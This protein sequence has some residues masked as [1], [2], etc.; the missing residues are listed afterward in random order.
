MRKKIKKLSEYSVFYLVL[1]V[2]FFSILALSMFNYFVFLS[3]SQKTYRE[4]FLNY[5]QKVTDLA[6]RNIDQQI[7][8]VIYNIPQ[9]YFSDTKQNDAFLKPQEEKLE[10]R[11]AEITNLISGLRLIQVSY[12]IIESMDLYYE[13]TRTVVTGFSNVHF[14]G[15]IEELEKFLP[16]YQEF[17]QQ[18]NDLYFMEEST[19]VYPAHEPVLTYVR[20]IAFPRWEGS[21]VV[22]AL[23]ISAS[24]FSDYIDESVGCLKIQ[25][26]DRRILYQ[27]SGHEDEAAENKTVLT[28]ESSTTS[29]SYEYAIADSVLYADVNTTNRVFLFNFILSIL[30]NIALLLAISRY[31]G[32]IYRERLV[33]L[34]E[35]AGM[36]IGAEYKSFDSSL[37]HLRKEIQ[38]LSDTANSSKALRFQSAV[39]ALIL[40]RRSD[41]T[42]TVLREYL[43]YQFC[44][45]L[46]IQR[47][48][49]EKISLEQIQNQMDLWGRETECHIL[50]TTM[51]RGEVVGLAN[52]P[53]EQENTVLP[54]LIEILPTYFGECRVAVGTLCLAEKEEIKKAYRSA[55]EIARYW[56]IYPG[57]YVLYDADIQPGKLRDKG[58]HLKLFEAIEKDINTENLLEFKLHLEM[59]VV[60]FQS[61]S[62]TM[63]YCYS[64]LRD[65]VTMICRI[66]QHRGLDMWVMYG[67][68]I[69]EYYKQI[70][71]IESFRE[72]M[73]GVCEILLK[74]IR[75]KRAMIDTDGEFKS[76]L[77]ALIEE[78]LEN[79]ISLDLLCDKLSMRP[80]ALSRVFKQVMG[81]GYTEYV[82][83]QK[84]NRAIALMKDD[85]SI[86]EIAEKLGYSS[87]QYFIKIFKE[88]Y[89]I[90]PYQY[91]KNNF[92]E[93]S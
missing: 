88:V 85:Y 62:Y 10:G 73:N 13:N 65:L 14:P 8:Q 84:L 3:S 61:G 58:S 18:D 26:P 72:W 60:S 82:K 33:S 87:S 19:D 47:S 40:N 29:L 34:S 91:K 35:E 51:E 9:L 69:R 78:N 23:H 50:L 20:R 2:N 79:D 67:Y 89:G 25:A 93:K 86:K 66:I 75:Q 38:S 21:G 46:M 70:R 45:V 30:F 71:D 80:D 28:Y 27:S 1:L 49:V 90:T 43:N 17:A 68:D 5:N 54:R 56:F 32:R 12:P 36:A 52:F 55:C 83:K 37:Q 15:S 77:T 11:A 6:F 4:S 59:L 7:M 16:W 53:K 64:T 42:Y 22:V 44:R 24:V 63:N 57:K 48:E 76:R 31:S 81:E 74:N 39:R 92:S 41:E